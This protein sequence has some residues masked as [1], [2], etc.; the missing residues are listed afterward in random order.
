MTIDATTTPAMAPWVRG[1]EVHVSCLELRRVFGGMVS[2][3]MWVVLREGGDEFPGNER[4]MTVGCGN[5]GLLGKE[6]GLR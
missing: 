2:E 6:L 1:L 3:V 4:W 5:F